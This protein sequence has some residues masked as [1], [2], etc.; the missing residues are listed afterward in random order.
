MQWKNLLGRGTRHASIALLAALSFSACGGDKESGDASRD[1]RAGD[2]D[3]E[4][5]EARS[6]TPT[7]RIIDVQMI[8]DSKGERYDPT[9]LKVERGDSLRFVLTSGVH[10]VHFLA[11]KNPP[12]VKLPPMSAYLQL[13]GQKMSYLIDFPKGRY[14]FQCDIHVM[15]GMIGHVTVEDDK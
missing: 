2:L 3:E 5:A 12:G 7:G 9:E 13:P 10:N 6:V 11:S 4:R 15:L 1:R 14:Y 8:T